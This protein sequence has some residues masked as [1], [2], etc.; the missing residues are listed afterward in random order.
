MR[1]ARASALAL[2]CDAVDGDFGLVHRQRLGDAQ[3]RAELIHQVQV[4]VEAQVARVLDHPVGTG[5]AELGDHL[6]ATG[7]QRAIFRVVP[8]SPEQ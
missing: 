1:R 7:I 6:L 5:L 3:L 2:G 4:R 8:A